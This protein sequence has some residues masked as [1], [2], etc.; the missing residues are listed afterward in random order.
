VEFAYEDQ[1]FWDLRRWKIAADVLNG[2]QLLA[3]KITKQ[4]DGSF[5]YEKVPINHP[6]SKMV[7]LER[8]YLFPIDQAELGRDSK[9]IQNPDY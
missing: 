2:L 3:M 4:S 9:L 1:R 6:N 7:F 8:N 5:T